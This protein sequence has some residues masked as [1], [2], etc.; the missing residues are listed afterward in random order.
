[1]A[2]WK[3][4]PFFCLPAFDGIRVVSKLSVSPKRHPHHMAHREI[5]GLLCGMA[6][7]GNHKHTELVAGS[8]PPPN[9]T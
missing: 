4:V 6:L 9:L 8:S 7:K 2:H 5:K 1:M 3:S